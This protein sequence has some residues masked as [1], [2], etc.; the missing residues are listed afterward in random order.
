MKNMERLHSLFHKF[1]APFQD[2]AQ[3]L[4][5]WFYPPLCMGCEGF[6]ADLHHFLCPHCLGGLE[7]VSHIVLEDKL[8]QLHLYQTALHEGFALWMFD[9]GGTIQKVQHALKY[10]NR[11]RLAF[12]IGVLMGEAYRH[13]TPRLH[14]EPT[15]L[16][17]VPLSQARF[18]ERGY[19]QAAEIALGF[20]SVFPLPVLSDVLIRAKN[21]RSQTKLNPKQRWQN[22]ASAF[23]CHPKTDLTNQ[24]VFLVDDVLT[25]G[26]TLAGAAQ[27]L[28]EVGAASV[29]TLTFAVVR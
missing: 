6:L 23:Q 28:F 25:T 7:R 14:P 29:R 20:A 1:Q 11:P 16:I 26:A 15:V 8:N 27:P 21:T 3:G 2:F 10:Q 17:P 4:Q 22:V 18:L 5:T 19:N 13:Y 9:D 24:H 12:Q